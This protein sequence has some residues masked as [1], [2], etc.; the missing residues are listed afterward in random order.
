MNKELLIDIMNRSGGIF[1][2]TADWTDWLMIIIGLVFC[3]F[4]ALLMWLYFD[5]KHEWSET[6]SHYEQYSVGSFKGMWGRMRGPIV[7]FVAVVCLLIGIA[8]IYS[9]CTGVIPDSGI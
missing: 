6:S 1:S 2:S 8:F 3:V 9:G 5:K 7:L 4:T